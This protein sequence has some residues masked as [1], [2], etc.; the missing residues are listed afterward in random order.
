[1][2]NIPVHAKVFCADGSTGGH[3]SYVVLNP[4]T[5]Q[6]THVVVK[7]SIWPEDERLVPIEM[8]TESAQ[9]HIRLSCS[10]ERLAEMDPFIETE[11]LE[12][13]VPHYITDPFLLSWPYQ[14]VDME[15][16]QVEHERI[17]V[18]E[19]AIRR[20]ARVEAT[21]GYIGH[22]DGFLV[23]QTSEHI[24][25]L[26]LREGH[27]WGQKDVSIP[28][29]YIDRIEEDVVYLKLDKQGIENL[30]AATARQP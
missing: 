12:A 20:G 8:V 24:T 16:V 25:H 4:V 30:P 7:R 29:S 15:R 14:Q 19:L 5:E 10:K 28:V 22:V 1:M 18:G 2:M 23:D 17:P 11:F 9:D 27:L 26:V 13:E 6:I 21:D 3:T